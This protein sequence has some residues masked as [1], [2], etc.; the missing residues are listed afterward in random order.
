MKKIIL[1]VFLSFLAL[2]LIAGGVLFAIGRM[3]A[4]EVISEKPIAVA[5]GEYTESNGY[6]PYEEI[7][8]DFVRAV[9][10]VED[11]RYFTRKGLDWIALIRALIENIQAGRLAEGGSTISQQIAKNLYFGYQRSGLSYKLA[12]IFVMVDMEEA[13]S[14]EE[15]FALYACMNYYGD[16]YYGLK[17]AAMGYYGKSPSDL[18]TAE[19]AML[20]GL[21]NAPSVYQL[22]SGFEL[23]KKRQEKVLQCMYNNEAISAEEYEKALQEDV[24]PVPQ[25]H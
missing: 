17:N 24:S 19:A 4:D 10:S 25:D 18:S 22:S 8:E 1:K 20:A 14:K 6:V 13:Y 21:P 7:D 5:I 9:I 11:K 16:D 23:A 12:E 15:L 2:L 3:R